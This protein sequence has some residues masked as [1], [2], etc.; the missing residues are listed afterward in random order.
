M[1]LSTNQMYALY[2]LGA[3][4]L[5]SYAVDFKSVPVVGNLDVISRNGIMP[6][7]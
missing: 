5:I 6:G 3:W 2:G 4:L 1:N 7:F